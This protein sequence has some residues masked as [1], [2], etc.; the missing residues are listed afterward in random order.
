[1]NINAS[2]LRPE[3]DELVSN[4][5]ALQAIT[6]RTDLTG[7]ILEAVVKKNTKLTDAEIELAKLVLVPLWKLAWKKIK[8]KFKIG[9]PTAS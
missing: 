9:N 3:D 6:G 1:M 5:Q 8:A 4:V 2:N 7:P